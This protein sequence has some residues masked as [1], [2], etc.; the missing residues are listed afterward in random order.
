MENNYTEYLTAF[1]NLSL[2]DKRDYILE[3]IDEIIKLFYKVN[4]DYNNNCDILSAN[5]YETEEEYLMEL[6]KKII[7]LKGVSGV[8]AKIIADNLYE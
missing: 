6:F 4:L 8:T 7:S 2:E 5:E 3:N 1:N